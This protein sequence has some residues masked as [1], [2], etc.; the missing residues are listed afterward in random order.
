VA[1][2]ASRNPLLS[3]RADGAFTIAGDKPRT[4]QPFTFQN[5]IS[6]GYFEALGIPVKA[7]QALTWNDWGS[8]RRVA[9]VNETLTRTYFDGTP[10]LSRRIGIGTRADTNTEI[11]GVVGDARYHDLRGEFPP[12]TFLNLDSILDG[13]GRVNVYARVSRD[14]GEMMPL[15]RAEVARIDPNMVV[16][17]MRTLDDQIGFQMS[18]E[19]ML[20]MLS[21]GFAAIATLL[22]VLGVH[23]VLTFQVARRTREM[24]VRMALGAGR[25]VIVRLVASEMLG[26]ILGGLA[27]GVVAGYLGGQLIQTQLFGLDARNPAVFGATIGALVA[28][29]SVATLIPAFRASRIDPVGALRHE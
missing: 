24:G 18:N 17:G 5:G 7:G 21:V 3:G 28:A 4:E 27:V 19:R 6:P 26:V 14:P 13:I 20:S 22:A 23:G 29:A 11:I 16:S 25:R 12:Q 1:V 9:F 8:G 10:P 15:F 2:G